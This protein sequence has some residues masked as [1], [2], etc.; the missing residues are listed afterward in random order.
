MLLNGL[1]APDF[2]AAPALVAAGA[3]F[4][5]G[6]SLI[7]AIGAQ[8]MF[9]LRQGLLREHVFAVALFCALAD[10]L[11]IAAGVLGLGAWVQQHPALLVA[12]RYGG[13]LFLL[14][15]GFG[16]ARR[17]W[18]GSAGLAAAGAGKESEPKALRAVLAQAAA[19]TFLN[20]H[21]YLDTVVLVGSISTR[22]APHHH[23][24][25]LGAALGSVVWF[26]SLAYG[27]RL[28]QPL[29]ARPGA[30]RVLDGAIALVML[31]LAVALV[32]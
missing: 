9:V 13:A 31:A 19:F 32:A 23:T 14:W 10:A 17:A 22:F 21:C 4:A 2:L 20:P 6:L 28:L 11:L 7:V 27:A 15:Y 25:G 30:W 5:A 12:L 1:W 26:F 8:N 3:G 29:L 16:A 24:F 18:A